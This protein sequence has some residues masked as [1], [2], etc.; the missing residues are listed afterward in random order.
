MEQPAFEQIPSGDFSPAAVAQ[1]DPDLWDAVN[2]LLFE[3]DLRKMTSQVLDDR[4]TNLPRVVEALD[5][6]FGDIPDPTLMGLYGDDENGQ[7]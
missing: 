4:H 6:W 2:D 1:R 5:N 7:A 3:F